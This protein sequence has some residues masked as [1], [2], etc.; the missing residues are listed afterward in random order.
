MG[1][2][3][4]VPWC[5]RYL[6]Q[7]KSQY[8]SVYKSDKCDYSEHTEYRCGSPGALESALL[9]KFLD[10]LFGVQFLLVFKPRQIRT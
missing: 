2:F 6:D 10:S 5:G 8:K 1:Q 7:V 3:V 4:G 9:F